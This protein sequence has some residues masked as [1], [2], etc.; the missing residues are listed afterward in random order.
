MGLFENKK[1]Q[2]TCEDSK[3]KKLTL[4]EASK[5]LDEIDKTMKEMNITLNK[6]LDKG[7]KANC[8]NE[9]TM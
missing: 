3:S 9:V 4:E 1:K 6:I 5:K 7:C 8:V 2:E